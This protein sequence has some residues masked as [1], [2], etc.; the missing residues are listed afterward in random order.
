MDHH[1][2]QPGERDG[3]DDQKK[4]KCTYLN[5]ARR[6]NIHRVEFGA[7]LIRYQR[8]ALDRLE[9]HCTSDRNLCA[10]DSGRE[11]ETASA[12]AVWLYDLNTVDCSGNGAY[13]FG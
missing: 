6:P 5:R 12:A 7:A 2:A 13:N 4:L 11:D 8:L 9:P 10:H 3:R 1:H